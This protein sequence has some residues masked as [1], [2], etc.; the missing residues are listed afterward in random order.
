M[1]VTEPRNRTVLLVEDDLAL[2][3]MLSDALRAS[4]YD[5]WHVE[6]AG[7]A[8]AAL[9]QV[10]PDLIL[11]D[12]MLPD[13]NG[14]VMCARLKARAG[15]PL[16][17]CSATQRKD[18]VAIGLQLGAD[19][20]LRKPFSLDEL[21]ARMDIALRH[22]AAPAAPAAHTSPADDQVARIGRL[23]IDKTR[24]I[25]TVGGEALRLTPTEYQLLSALAERDGA[26]VSRHELAEHVWGCVDDGVMRSLD[27][28][29]RRLRAKLAAVAD[30][31]PYLV[32]RRGFGY[33]LVDELDP[34]RAGSPGP[35]VDSVRGSATRP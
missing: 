15:A 20:F 7:D 32:T 35:A 3:C 9:A 34:V 17:I 16:I 30:G 12:L 23:M 25:V 19:D 1:A 6:R 26:L 8:E 4:S 28:H 27:V 2:A 33:Q 24:C 10:H 13:R 31:G 21:Q 14:L 29:M 5:V 11:L 22:I 18:D